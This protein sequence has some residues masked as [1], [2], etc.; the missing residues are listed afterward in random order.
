LGNG[1]RTFPRS[2]E[3][4]AMVRA[5]CV[6]TALLLPR[7]DFRTAYIRASEVAFMRE[8]DRDGKTAAIIVAVL[9]ILGVASF[10]FAGITIVEHSLATATS[11]SSPATPLSRG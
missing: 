5:S 10:V 3:L 4:H 11:S 6:T 9:A 1:K 2:N 8:A 7:A